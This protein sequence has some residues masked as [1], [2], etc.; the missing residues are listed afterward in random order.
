MTE[1]KATKDD[2]RKPPLG[3]IN[4]EFKAEMASALNFGVDAY[5][6]D[7]WLLDGGL[8]LDR[9]CDAIER[10][11]DEFRKGISEDPETSLSHLAHAATGCM[12]AYTL[13]RGEGN[14]L[15]WAMRDRQEFSQATGFKNTPPPTF[16]DVA[17]SLGIDDVGDDG[18]LPND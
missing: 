4:P 15:L 16:G 10:H 5:G 13:D 7:N 1:R 12:M 3:L 6:L 11:L 14:R 8:E 18:D 9:I 17:K 2:S